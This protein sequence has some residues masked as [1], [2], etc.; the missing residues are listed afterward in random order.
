MPWFIPEWQILIPFAVASLVLAITP[1]PD[2]AFL[3]GRTIVQGQRAGLICVLGITLGIAVHTAAVAVGLSA[4]LAASVTAFAILKYAGA[5][6]LLWLAYQ[7][8]RH[9]AQLQLSDAPARAPAY[10]VFWQALLINVLNPKVALFFLTFLP[11]FVD[12][13]DPAVMGKLLF[14]GGAFSIIALSA[15]LPL[16]WF[17]EN[18]AKLLRSSRLAMRVFD[19]TFATIL[20]A[21]A[22]KLLA[23]RPA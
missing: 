15:L 10:L 11:Q 19:W 1:G 12:P 22:V 6:Y 2:M 8:L 4:L 5:L 13:A 17:A 9:G 21:F 3:L 18:F 23:A 20:G 7:T 14:L 16:I